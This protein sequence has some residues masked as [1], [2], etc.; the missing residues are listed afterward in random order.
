MK[1][2]VRL[3]AFAVIE[4]AFLQAALAVEDAI[5]KHLELARELVATVKPENNNYEV[6]GPGR[7]VRWKGDFLTSENT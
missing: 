3:V 2:I 7:G 4:L 5:P 6:F 1:K